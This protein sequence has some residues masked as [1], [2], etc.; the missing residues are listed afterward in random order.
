MAQYTRNSR[1]IFINPKN[2]PLFFENFIIM[3]TRKEK[4]QKKQEILTEFIAK[5]VEIFNPFVA[6]MKDKKKDIESRKRTELLS[7]RDKA[8]RIVIGVRFV[9]KLLRLKWAD[10][11][12]GK[13]SNL[14]TLKNLL[15]EADEVANFF[16]K[17]KK[18]K[19]LLII[20]II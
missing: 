4:R 3:E 6:E 15:K 9:K 11:I 7:P 10:T 14:K 19:R 1:Y 13:D 5:C 18:V 17:S 8:V 12:L 20:K 16:L 2:R